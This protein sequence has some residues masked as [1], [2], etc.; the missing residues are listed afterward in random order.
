LT[1]FKVHKETCSPRK[2]AEEAEDEE[3]STGKESKDNKFRESSPPERIEKEYALLSASQLSSL[4]TTTSYLE[5]LCLQEG[6][7]S[8][9]VAL[10]NA[11][12]LQTL[13]HNILSPIPKSIDLTEITTE[14]ATPLESA[15]SILQQVREQESG[16]VID[17]LESLINQIHLIS[18]EYH[19]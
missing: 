8:D 9:L 1:C 5:Y 11:P 7:N 10:M 2:L 19:P 12:A 6:K 13:F 3:I 14:T 16:P 17:Q 4:R 15:L 18:G